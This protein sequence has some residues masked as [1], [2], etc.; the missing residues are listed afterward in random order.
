M[1]NTY[2]T[3]EMAVVALQDMKSFHDEMVTVFEKFGMDLFDNLGRRNIV[4]S[5]AQEK[6]FA[7][8]LGVFYADV[9]A[10]G[11]SGQ[12]DIIIGSLDKELECKL[13]SR[14]VSG[15]ISFQSDFE[16]LSKKGPLDYL[17][18]IGDEKFEKFA[19]LHFIGLTTD[20]FRTPSTGS[21]GRVQMLKYKGF[22]KCNVLL[23]NIECLNDMYVQQLQ[24][25]IDIA[26]NDNDIYTKRYQKLL[27]RLE[28]WKNNSGRYNI[29]LEEISFNHV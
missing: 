15:A 11:K 20:D 29:G 23:G 9:Q 6:F 8:A 27:T 10:D 17:Y 4:M 24:E 16:T 25:E 18:V 21:R 22:Q 28:F 19:V 1:N 26:K 2:L 7:Q 12:P 3:K 5:Q 14:H 13:T